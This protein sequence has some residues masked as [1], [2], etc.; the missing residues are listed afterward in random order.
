MTASPVAAGMTYYDV[1]RGDAGAD[2]LSGGSGADTFA[3]NAGADL[4]T[5]FEIGN[6]ELAVLA[7][8]ALGTTGAFAPDD[9]RFYAAAGA[10]SGQDANDRVIY[11]T[12][13]GN[14]YYDPDGS[15]AEAATLMFTLQGAPTLAATDIAVQDYSNLLLSFG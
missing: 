5:D 3:W 7:T 11:D 2:T 6:D 4:I 10:T 9:P 12:S 8:A 1:L 15:S 13:T 14:V